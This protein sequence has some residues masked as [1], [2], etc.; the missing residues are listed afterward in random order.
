[1]SSDR[2][3]QLQ[4]Q[5]S[6]DRQQQLQQRM[7]SDGNSSHAYGLLPGELKLLMDTK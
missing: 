5:M 1:M 4:Q 3:R 6:S 7:S 2:Q